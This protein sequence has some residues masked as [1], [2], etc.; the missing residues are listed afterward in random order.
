M[1][2]LRRACGTALLAALAVT[3]LVPATAARAVDPDPIRVSVAT[4]DGGVLP[5][6]CVLVYAVERDENQEGTFLTGEACAQPDGADVEIGPELIG[7]AQELVLFVRTSAMYAD[8]WV[9]G[10]SSWDATRWH[11][12]DDVDVVLSV[13]G[14]L[15]GQVTYPDGTPV[16]AG[17]V[18]VLLPEGGGGDVPAWI[19]DGRWR[20]KVA[21]GTYVLSY[22]VDGRVQYSG[23]A[24]SPFL[25]RQY[26][27]A[28]GEELAVQEVFLDEGDAGSATVTGVVTQAGTGAALRGMCV[29]AVDQEWVPATASAARTAV[30]ASSPG[31]AGAPR[32]IAPA[33]CPEDGVL[34]DAEGGYRLRSLAGPDIRRKVVVTDPSAQHVRWVSE[35]FDFPVAAE[36]QQDAVLVRAGGLAGRVVD[37]VSG[38]PLA[39][40]CPQ[41]FVSRS[42]R[43]SEG[44]VTC[45]D[46]DG[47]WSVSGLAP[48]RVTVSLTPRLPHL[49]LYVPGAESS[50]AAALVSV[51]AGRQAQVPQTGL[52]V[53]GVL[54]GTVR[55]RAGKP[56]RG[57]LVSFGTWSDGS[58]PEAPNARTDATGRYVVSGLRP[59]SDV[60]Q[61][62]GWEQSGRKWARSWSGVADPAEAKPVVVAYDTTTRFDAVATRAGSVSVA[63]SGRALP[64]DEYGVGVEAFSASGRSLGL[65]SWA[66]AGA[67]PA[68]VGELPSGAV[69]LRARVYTDAGT[70]SW[71]Y[72]APGAGAATRTPVQVR[73]GATTTVTWVIDR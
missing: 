42:W 55:D 53:G 26:T 30:R 72:R 67:S 3:S 28:A 23:G 62:A 32:R 18:S 66:T 35:P 6:V 9:G 50:R 36:V 16:A 29:R 33:G 1:S 34:T 54:T 37:R 40:V 47:R 73:A 56:V 11:P 31:G 27:V 48:G 64:E 17:D 39:G 71:W 69:L 49:S 14:A 59:G 70:R 46:D 5:D 58:G 4:E 41:V 21:A 19:E 60:V 22:Q 68:L 20:A 43:T 24:D 25:A 45:S 57:V 44:T 63:L 38:E 8:T 13:A 12:G 51:V 10:R 61:V 2:F 15:V 65:M 52:P 7:Q